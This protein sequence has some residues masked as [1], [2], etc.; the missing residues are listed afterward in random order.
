[1]YIFRVKMNSFFVLKAVEVNL[2]FLAD[3]SKNIHQQNFVA[4]LDTAKYIYSAFPVSRLDV[5]VGMGIISSN[6]EIIFGFDKYFDK[7]NLDKAVSDIDYPGSGSAAH[8]GKALTAAKDLL[9]GAGAR[10]RVRNVLVV[11][12]G[13]KSVDDVTEAVRG[14]RDSKVEVFCVSIGNGLDSTYLGTIASVPTSLHGVVTDYN[15]LAEGA[16]ET[17][18][19]LEIAKVEYSK[20]H[21]IGESQLLINFYYNYA[22]E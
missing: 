7:P 10:K 4:L 17:I 2:G 13:G 9:F 18:E 16:L 14:L 20:S 21:N 11:L 3:G 1:M 19:K 6:P 5:R 15:S 22:N 12:L 8:V